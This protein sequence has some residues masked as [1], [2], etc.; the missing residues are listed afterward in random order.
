M[1][2]ST[3][4]SLSR[5]PNTHCAILGLASHPFMENIIQPVFPQIPRLALDSVIL[6]QTTTHL[7]I[8]M[9]EIISS[10]IT[11]L[12]ADNQCRLPTD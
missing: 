9:A 8:D 5:N 1:D 12:V 2:G 3:F 11:R 10:T 4:D 6:P 7:N